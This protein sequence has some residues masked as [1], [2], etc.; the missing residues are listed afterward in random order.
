MVAM[1]YLP[2]ACSYVSAGDKGIEANEEKYLDYRKRTE[3]LVKQRGSMRE[4]ESHNDAWARCFLL[5]PFPT[6]IHQQAKYS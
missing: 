4:C 5:P 3:E 1:R 2:P 6:S